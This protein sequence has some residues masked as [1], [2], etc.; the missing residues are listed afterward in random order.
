VSQYEAP[1]RIELPQGGVIRGTGSYEWPIEVDGALPANLKVVQLSSTGSGEVV[2]DN[3]SV[4]GEALF[5]V[6]KMVGT[7]EMKPP[8][9]MSGVPIG[10]EQTVR[11]P[12][13]PGA[14]GNGA[15]NSGESSSDCAVNAPGRAAAG[16]WLA[17]VSGGVAALWL[18]RRRRT[19]S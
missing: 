7:G 19:R 11:V 10:G 16:G 1:W 2:A 15:E 3:S 18:A 17:L 14:N 8:K 12:S 4:I 5:K 6:S 13:A 9:P